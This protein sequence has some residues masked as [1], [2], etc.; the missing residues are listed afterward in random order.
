MA[1]LK[2][3]AGTI[4]D[5]IDE[6]T[7]TVEAIHQS[8]ADFSLGIFATIKPLEEVV[9]EVRDVQSEAIKGVYGLIRGINDRI[10][11]IAGEVL[12]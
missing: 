12:A 10:G 1:T 9:T 6:G 7:S 3:I 4:H 8:I 5:T 2:T 11:E